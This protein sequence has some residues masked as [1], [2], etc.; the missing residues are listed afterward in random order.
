MAQAKGSHPSH[1]KIMEIL[2][3]NEAD[4]D[5]KNIHGNVPLA[6][7]TNKSGRQVIL[8]RM[9]NDRYEDVGVETLLSVKKLRSDEQALIDTC[10]KVESEFATHLLDDLMGSLEAGKRSFVQPHVISRAETLLKTLDAKRELEKSMDE[11]DKIRPCKKSKDAEDLRC[12]CLPAGSA[13]SRWAAGGA[14]WRGIESVDSVGERRTRSGPHSLPPPFVT[15]PASKVLRRHPST[16][17]L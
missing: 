14:R 16:K 4:I 7:C 2:L 13:A 12:A 11:L 17:R 1:V 8:Q 6:L 15:Q 3:A 10:N 9:L 5:V